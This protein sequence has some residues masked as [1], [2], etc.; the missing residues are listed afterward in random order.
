MFGD[1]TQ[2]LKDHLK[3]SAENTEKGRKGRGFRTWFR[4]GAQLV[5]LDKE[6]PDNWPASFSV[7]VRTVPPPLPRSH[8]PG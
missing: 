4:K 5:L 8:L 6:V 3:A 2:A 1:R 7:K